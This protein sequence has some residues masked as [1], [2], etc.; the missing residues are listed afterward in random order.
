MLWASDF[1]HG[2]RTYSAGTATDVATDA[3][4]EVAAA[5][6]AAWVIRGILGTLDFL[7]ILDILGILVALG[8]LGILSILGILGILCILRI[9]KSN[10]QHWDQI[11]I[12]GIIY[13]QDLF[14]KYR[15][16]SFH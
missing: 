2:R 5:G 1:G 11:S 7:G 14:A 3:V 10:I 15:K 4:A 12:F 13:S 8:I 9:Q 16:N 6:A